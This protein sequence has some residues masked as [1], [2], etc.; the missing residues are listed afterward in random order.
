MTTIRKKCLIVDDE[1]MITMYLAS[2]AEQYDFEVCGIATNCD[3]A[4]EMALL[5]KPDVILMDVRLRGETDGVDASIRIHEQLDA[6]IIFI[7][8][9]Q[10]PATLDRILTDNPYSILF[11]PV[12]PAELKHAMTV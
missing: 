4:V 1:F 11:K 10:E 9:S 8:G 7:T 6:R 5:H 2:L 3:D 12:E